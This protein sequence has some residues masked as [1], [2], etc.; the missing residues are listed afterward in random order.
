M[1]AVHQINH[2]LL[3]D[4]DDALLAVREIEDQQDDPQSL[5]DGEVIAEMLTPLGGP[6]YLRTRN[7]VT[8]QTGTDHKVWVNWICENEKWKPCFAVS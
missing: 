2:R 1:D 7:F 8:L 5:G 6:D 3:A 4:A